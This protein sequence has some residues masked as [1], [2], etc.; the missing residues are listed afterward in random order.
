M[1]ALAVGVAVQTGVMILCNL[2]FTPLFLGAPMGDVVAM[3]LPVILPFNLMKSGINAV[4]TYIIYKPVS[5]V[6]H[7]ILGRPE[8]AEGQEAGRS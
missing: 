1:V 3:L 7:R 4:V 2:V 8:P 5:R 6:A